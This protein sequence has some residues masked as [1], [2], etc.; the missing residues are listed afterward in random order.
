LINSR[1]YELWK[2]VHLKQNIWALNDI[3]EYYDFDIDFFFIQFDLKKVINFTV[4]HLILEAGQI[5]DLSRNLFL[6]IGGILAVSSVSSRNSI[7]IKGGWTF[8]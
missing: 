5:A 4:L 6:E 7:L 1:K 3:F 2:F 8:Q